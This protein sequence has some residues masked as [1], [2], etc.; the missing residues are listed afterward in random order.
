MKNVLFQTELGQTFLQELHEGLNDAYRKSAC[1]LGDMGENFYHFYD[2]GFEMAVSQHSSSEFSGE[3]D[4]NGPIRSIT[5]P[6]TFEGDPDEP[7]AA[8]RH[9][10]RCY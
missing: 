1:C 10:T 5:H 9:G 8:S 4:R 7:L 2:Y 3:Y 6:P